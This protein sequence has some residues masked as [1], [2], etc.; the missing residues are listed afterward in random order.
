MH[1]IRNGRLLLVAAVEGQQK[2]SVYA[3]RGCIIEDCG[4]SAACT[5]CLLGVETIFYRKHVMPIEALALGTIAE[6]DE[7]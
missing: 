1:G 3:V 4:S 7:D 2:A 6:L 5:D